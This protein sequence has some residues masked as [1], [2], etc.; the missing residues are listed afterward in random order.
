MY[1]IMIVD[2]DKAIRS[3]LPKLLDFK[4]FGFQVSAVA[5]DGREA[6][7][8]YAQEPTDLIFLDIHMPV[9]DG[10]GFLQKLW[11]QYGGKMPYVVIISASRSFECA[12]AA[13]RY[14]VKRYLTKPVS[15]EEL[16]PLLSELK[17]SLDRRYQTRR[18]SDAA[19]CAKRVRE[20]YQKGNGDRSGLQ[21]FLLMHCVTISC[22]EEDE[23]FASLR[24]LLA[25][26]IA[27]G[28]EAFLRARGSVITYLVSRADMES[29]QGSAALF[30][31]HI[32]YQL[33]QSGWECAILLDEDIFQK[34]ESTFRGDYDLH[35]YRMMSEVFWRGGS[36]ITSGSEMQYVTEQSEQW[37]DEEV[38]YFLAIKQAIR[39]GN[40]EQLRQTFDR[41]MDA[42]D[43]SQLNVVYL[44]EICFRIYYTLTDALGTAVS[45][46][47]PIDIR[48]S[49][50]FLR[51][52]AWKDQLWLQIWIGYTLFS[53][54]SRAGQE[55]VGIRAAEY[56][57]EHFREPVTIKEAADYLFVS[58]SYLARNFKS[59]VGSSFK[60]YLNQLRLEEAKRLLHHTDMKIYEIAEA[61]GFGESK[62][63]VT[64]FTSV[65][66]CTPAE[67]RK[68][69]RLGSEPPQLSEREG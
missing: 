55:D 65:E 19:E 5:K 68:N 2:D 44:Q 8:R 26:Q 27:G 58:S 17:G 31:R 11:E 13:I 23:D 64:K 57:R 49:A 18:R 9:L 6:L 62:Y 7:E 35:L 4:E 43:A 59:A 16:A 39:E 67:Y 33:R 30:G 41:M 52:S 50:F 48:D 69:I 14:G 24:E 56:L 15:G 12:Q 45:G 3:A 53:E 32:A 47:S 38:T 54:K 37:L 1:S 21:N 29:S 10:V 22:Q 61:A 25:G 46:L 42:I 66:G 28:A 60:H 40:E 20:L 51:R 36:V 34:E 63:F